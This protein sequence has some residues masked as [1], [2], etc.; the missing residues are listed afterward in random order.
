MQILF[1]RKIGNSRN[2]IKQRSEV[3][4]QCRHRSKCKLKTL[5]TNKKNPIKPPWN[6]IIMKVVDCRCPGVQMLAEVIR[7]GVYL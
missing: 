6:Y 3:I 5:V 4:S 7:G 1:L 2:I